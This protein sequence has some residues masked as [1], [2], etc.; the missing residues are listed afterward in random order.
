[1]LSAAFFAF[2]IKQGVGRSHRIFWPRNW[3]RL[4]QKKSPCQGKIVPTERLRPICRARYAGSSSRKYD[5]STV[6]DSAESLGATIPVVER[7]G[8]G[9]RR[10]MSVQRQQI[11]P[12]RWRYAVT[13]PA[14]K[15]WGQ[16]RRVLAT[17][18]ASCPHYEHSDPNRRTIT[19]FPTS[20]SP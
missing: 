17:Q 8:S 20:V 7:P 2:T 5:N 1:V 15:A 3:R 11:T 12:L 14:H 13:P 16:T 19:G 18:A 4:P 10:D 9:E 6:F